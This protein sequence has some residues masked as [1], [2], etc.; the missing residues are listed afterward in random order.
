M[1]PPSVISGERTFGKRHQRIR[2]HLGSRQL[3][4]IARRVDERLPKVFAI[5]GRKT[6]HHHVE[7][8]PARLQRHGELVNIGLHLHVAR[9]KPRRAQILSQ[10]LDRR[11]GPLVLVRQ[12]QRGPFARKRLRDRVRN[13]PF[14]PDA[15]NNGRLSFH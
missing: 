2:A 8:V 14:V 9:V 6:V 4:S 15:K 10:V 3:E 13:A 12:Q 11:F 1:D 5:G 7:L